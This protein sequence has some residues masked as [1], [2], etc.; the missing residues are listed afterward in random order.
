MIFPKHYRAIERWYNRA[1][2][3]LFGRQVTGCDPRGVAWH[4]LMKI[5]CSIGLKPVWGLGLGTVWA[6]SS[7]WSPRPK[8]VWIWQGRTLA[9]PWFVLSSQGQIKESKGQMANSKV[10]W[11]NIGWLRNP[12]T[13]PQKARH[14][15]LFAQPPSLSNGSWTETARV[16]VNGD[17]LVFPPSNY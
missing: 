16:A 11:V 14:A 10:Q 6:I 3:F 13:C 15:W 9:P 4:E 1:I 17:S 7:S 2:T 5:I 8:W 12:L